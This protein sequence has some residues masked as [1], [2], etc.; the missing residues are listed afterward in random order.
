M[1]SNALKT[2]LLLNKERMKKL[3]NRDLLDV[4][5]GWT[6][7]QATDSCMCSTSG[8]T[9]SCICGNSTVGNSYGECTH[10]CH[11]VCGSTADQ[12]GPL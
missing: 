1:G 12:G 11:A 3:S 7:N 4:A 5:G 8:A 9:A 6:T 10:T 2:K